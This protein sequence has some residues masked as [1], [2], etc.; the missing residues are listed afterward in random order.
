[1]AT[2]TEGVAWYDP[3]DKLPRWL[4]DLWVLSHPSYT[5]WHLAYV[6]IG[7]ALA[8]RLNW[9][10][11]GWA[12]L[13]FF[14]GM[15]IAGH[16]LDELNGRPLKTTL[17]TWLLWLLTGLGLGGALAIGIV[18]G[19]K[20][21]GWVIPC[22]VFGGFIVFAYNL[23]WGKGFFHHDYFFGIAW[24]AFP[25]VTA[26]IA[27]THTLS[28]DAVLLAAFALLY[29]MAQRKLSMQ[30]RFWRRKVSLLEGAYYLVGDRPVVP[31]TV[32]WGQSHKLTREFITG[33]YDLSLKLL[34]G[35]IVSIAVGLLILHLLKGGA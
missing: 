19:V 16:C 34:N 6:A 32:G 11:L 25:L 14:L 18:I 21:T 3:G 22:I 1:M 17:P 20:E 23:E 30:S 33:P 26:Y 8:P 4:R 12:V 13:A 35:A 29:S 31:G 5:I 9:A 10:V 27:Q 2:K 7:A 15:G 28:I 24:G